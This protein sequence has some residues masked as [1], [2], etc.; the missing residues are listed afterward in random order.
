MPKILTNLRIDEVSAVDRGAGDGVKILLMKHDDEPYWKREFSAEERKERARSGSALPDGSFPIDN[1]SDL[2]NAMQ[3]IGRAKNPSKAKA[4]IRSRARALGLT[5]QL[6]DAFKRDSTMSRFIDFFTGKTPANPEVISKA[7]EALAKSLASII[8]GGDDDAKKNEAF[9]ESLSQFEEYLGKHLSG[10]P[11]PDNPGDKA[12]LKELAK[13][14]GLQVADDAKDEDIQKAMAARFAKMDREIIE[15][16]MTPEERAF[17]AKLGGTGRGSSPPDKGDKARGKGPDEDRND[18]EIDEEITDPYGYKRPGGSHSAE[19]RRNGKNG[20][21]DDDDDGDDE[22]EKFRNMGREEREK[23]MRKHAN[24]DRPEY[25]R[26]M[27]ADNA[28]LRATVQKMQDERE[29]DDIK[30]RCVEYG[31]PTTKAAQV[32]KLLKVD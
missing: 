1:A 19:K 4:H 29:L 30:K 18:P 11:A 10:A 3:A 15:L 2:H 24:D 23:W 32:Q 21:G 14:L 22:K 31:I 7:T 17:Y 5:D 20:N 25:V 28:E 13:A 9:A 16:R 8:K 26:K 6:S 12:M 27:E